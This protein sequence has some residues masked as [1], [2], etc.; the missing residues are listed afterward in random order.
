MKDSDP[1]NNRISRQ[2]DRIEVDQQIGDR[3]D[4]ARRNALDSLDQ[5]APRVHPV[6]RIRP[7]PAFATVAALAF[8]V[9]LMLGPPEVELPA[10]EIDSL[11]ILTAED[12][13]EMY[14]DL[15]FYWWLE[16]EM[17]SQQG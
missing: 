5:A 4:Q 3:L 7:A 12:D 9:L 6:Y 17:D 16:Q 10:T 2:L 1:F 14:K 13:L 8:G 15:E 11:E